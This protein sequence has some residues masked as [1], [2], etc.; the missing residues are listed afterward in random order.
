MMR[1]I[2]VWKYPHV[3]WQILL[4]ERDLEESYS[5]AGIGAYE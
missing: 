5:A 2:F 4:K 3:K 1:G